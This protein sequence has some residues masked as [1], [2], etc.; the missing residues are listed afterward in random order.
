[1]SF[2]SVTASLS[3]SDVPVDSMS[4][5]WD[6]VLQSPGGYTKFVSAVVRY[7]GDGSGTVTAGDVLVADAPAPA[8]DPT[9]TWVGTYRNVVLSGRLVVAG[10]LP[11]HVSLVVDMVWATPDEDVSSAGYGGTVTN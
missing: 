6:V 9:V 8:G 2:K 4:G 7:N 10:S 11:S 5:A 3:G 1:M